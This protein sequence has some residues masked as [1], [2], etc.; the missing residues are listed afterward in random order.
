MGV[1]PNAVINHV[2]VSFCA[3]QAAPSMER[4]GIEPNTFSGKIG[5][6]RG[7]RTPVSF[8]RRLTKPLLSP[9]SH[10]GKIGAREET[11][12][13]VIWMSPRH[14]S[15]CMTFAKLERVGRVELPLPDW[16]SGAQPLCHTRKK[17]YVMDFTSFRSTLRVLGV[18]PLLPF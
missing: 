8:R 2:A 13:P 7:T 3:S 16:K 17:W 9:L 4:M 12:T 18:E 14:T 11:R 15:R 6:G 5:A 10:S 1:E